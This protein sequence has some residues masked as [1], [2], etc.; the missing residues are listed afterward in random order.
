MQ[1]GSLN[2][3]QKAYRSHSATL[4]VRELLN[5]FDCDCDEYPLT[6]MQA[7]F[8]LSDGKYTS[9][10]FALWSVASSKA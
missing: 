9:P 5:A 10:V 8:L 3:A 6:H 4:S 1:I 2:S 7:G